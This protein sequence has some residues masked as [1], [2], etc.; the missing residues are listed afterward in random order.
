M[1]AKK[2]HAPIKQLREAKKLADELLIQK[3]LRH[4]DSVVDTLVQTKNAVKLPGQPG[5]KYIPSPSVLKASVRV[6]RDIGRMWEIECKE[7][8]LKACDISDFYKF[9][10]GI[11]N[12]EKQRNDIKKE[13]EK[14]TGRFDTRVLDYSDA[15]MGVTIFILEGFA[16]GVT[17]NPET[18]EFLS[19]F[20]NW[21]GE[22]EKLWPQGQR[23]LGK[24]TQ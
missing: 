8:G 16:L 21:C 13:R 4:K 9:T 14:L 15:L 20:L 24:K 22:L 19:W 23:M 6:L 5:M 18:G 10:I 1:S 7:K 17:N 12:E 3:K 11:F 2:K